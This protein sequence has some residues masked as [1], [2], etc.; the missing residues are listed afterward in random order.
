MNIF[1][2]NSTFKENSHMYSVL[3]T[4]FAKEHLFYLQWYGH[5]CC[6]ETYWV[7]REPFDSQLM[8]FT[9]K[10]T[11]EIATQGNMTK[12]APGDLAIIDCNK[13]HIYHATGY[14]EFS[15][16]H[17][18][19]NIS[20]ELTKMIIERHG[21]VIHL[22]A[23]SL[24]MQ[25]FRQLAIRPKT[26]SVEGEI[27]ISAQL[28]LILSDLLSHYDDTRTARSAHALNHVIRFIDEHYAE[29]LTLDGLAAFA[30]MSKAAFCQKF[31]Q[32]AGVSPYEYI[33]TK[34][35]NRAR[36]L[37]KSTDTSVAEIAYA[38]GFQSPANFIKTFRT[39]TGITP[40]AFR[41]VKML[42]S[43]LEKT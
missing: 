27:G 39:R 23:S 33:L 4:A 32:S 20:N 38:V 19:G 26:G 42:P 8:I 10:G 41:K 29:S 18:N 16:L 25:L 5:F 24:S 11:G 40:H 12:C 3:P 21:H 43:D 28:N 30:S 1:S 35:I 34:R 6:D 36:E 9:D 2:D 14:W 37:L 15:W 22:T 13:P 7:E 17:F 31:K